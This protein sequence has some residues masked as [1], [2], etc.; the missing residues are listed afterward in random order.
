M[1]LHIATHN[2]RY[3]DLDIFLTCNTVDGNSFDSIAGSRV[4]LDQISQY[5]VNKFYIYLMCT[6]LINPENSFSRGG[7]KG[8]AINGT[9]Y[10]SYTLSCRSNRLDS[11]CVYVDNYCYTYSNISCCKSKKTPN[12]IL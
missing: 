7:N 9:Y 1:K 8:T 5:F 2:Y 4:K 11:C 3:M 6:C 10:Q 12:I